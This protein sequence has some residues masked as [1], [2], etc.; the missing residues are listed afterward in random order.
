MKIDDKTNQILNIDISK[1]R[2]SYWTNALLNISGAIFL[3]FTLIRK[4]WI[5]EFLLVVIFLYTI[6]NTNKNRNKYKKVI[7]SLYLF[8]FCIVTFLNFSGQLRNDFSIV[9]ISLAEKLCHWNNIIQ[10]TGKDELKTVGFIENTLQ[11]WDKWKNLPDD[12]SM[13]PT[14][15]RRLLDVQLFLKNQIMHN[16]DIINQNGIISDCNNSYAIVTDSTFTCFADQIH[17]SFLTGNNLINCLKLIWPEDE[18]IRMQKNL[19][20]NIGIALQEFEKDFFRE[21][22]PIFEI[23]IKNNTEDEIVIDKAIFEI[24]NISV[25]MTP[26]SY[27]GS[28]L[29]I[30]IVY[31]WTLTSLRD[32][33]FIEWFN[34]LNL[35][36]PFGFKSTYEPVIKSLIELDPPIRISS[37]S[38]IRFMVKISDGY[39]WPCDIRFSFCSIDKYKAKSKWYKFIPFTHPDI[40]I[41]K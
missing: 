1:I 2:I 23:I 3:Y 22:H 15:Y 39:R 11:L 12:L 33:S 4:P 31:D 37:K 21:K 14:H 26:R 9:R 17:N 25:D 24:K 30:A 41:Y 32:K 6:I 16:P 35:E 29:T 19:D 27:G 7:I 18:V 8:F 20:L 34:K 5:F 10:T 28:P 13:A 38:N 40:N 36:Y